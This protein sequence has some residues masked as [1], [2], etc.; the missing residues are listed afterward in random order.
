[1]AGKYE[2][3]RE[4]IRLGSMSIKSEDLPFTTFMIGYY[5]PKTAGNIDILF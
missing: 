1:M 3:Y 4:R 2:Y 5:L